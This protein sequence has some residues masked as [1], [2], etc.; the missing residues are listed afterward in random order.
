MLLHTS[1]SLHIIVKQCAFESTTCIWQ[2]WLL[3]KLRLHTVCL[4]HK[5]CTVIEY[6]IHQYMKH[7]K[8]APLQHATT[9]KRCLST[10][11][12]IQKWQIYTNCLIFV[13]YW[14]LK[15]RSCKLGSQT[16]NVHHSSSPYCFLVK[17]IGWKFLPPHLGVD[18]RVPCT[19][20]LTEHWLLI[21]GCPLLTSLFVL[22][23]SYA[24]VSARAPF[25]KEILNL[26]GNNSGKIIKNGT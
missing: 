1:I 10:V 21:V 2:L 3:C 19:C 11:I 17:V 9:L 6:S 18:F 5:R 12:L 7:V 25:V 14:L 13:L 16:N 24:A 22:V 15:L 20:P 23:T 4:C 26:S 8:S